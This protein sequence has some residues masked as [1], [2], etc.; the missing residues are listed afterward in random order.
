VT[1][2]HLTAKE[3]KNVSDNS[4]EIAVEIVF[5]RDFFMGSVWK[6]VGAGFG[7]FER[8]EMGVLFVTGKHVLEKFN[9]K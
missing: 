2:F 4:A 7:L 8:R 3:L 1:P 6:G 9:H 5:W